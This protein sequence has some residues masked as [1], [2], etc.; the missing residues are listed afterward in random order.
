MVIHQ[1]L[2]HPNIVKCHQIIEK[3]Y[4]YYFVLEY[5]SQGTLD[6]FIKKHEKLTE[7]TA[8]TIME[9]I[10]SAYK[11]LLQQKVLHRDLKPPNIL[12]SGNNW[13]I[14]DFGFSVIGKKSLIGDINVGTPAY[15]AP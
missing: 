15:M 6:S 5:C 8:V 3:T 7:S 11:Y 2:D 14:C 9:Q 1:Q 10:I 12:K 4:H 13:K